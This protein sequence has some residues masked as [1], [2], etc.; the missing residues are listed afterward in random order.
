MECFDNVEVVAVF[1]GDGFVGGDERIGADK[2][3][4]GQ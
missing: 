4:F 1:G 2:D 3:R